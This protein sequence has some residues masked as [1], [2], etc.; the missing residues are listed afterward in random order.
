[1]GIA[2][3]TPNRLKLNEIRVDSGLKLVDTVYTV[4]NLIVDTTGDNK[5]LRE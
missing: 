2:L 3:A 5:D 4:Y 1:M